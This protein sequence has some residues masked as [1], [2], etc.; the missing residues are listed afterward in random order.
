MCPFQQIS[1]L[2]QSVERQTLNKSL[3]GYEGLSECRGFEPHVG[4]IFWLNFLSPLF[5]Q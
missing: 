4:S 1:R 5:V 3:L 2:A